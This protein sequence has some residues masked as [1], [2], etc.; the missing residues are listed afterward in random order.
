MITRYFVDHVTALI[1]I[2]ALMFEKCKMCEPL[3]VKPSKYGVI[4]SCNGTFDFV[5]T[6]IGEAF[7]LSTCRKAFRASN[8]LFCRDF[9]VRPLF[10]GDIIFERVGQHVSTR[11][12]ILRHCST[13]HYA[14]PSMARRIR[15]VF[16]LIVLRRE[17]KTL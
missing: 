8:L 10:S 12:I 2:V 11:D 7:N 17:K 1:C 9:L 15:E 5:S 13:T 14:V 3:H 6:R 16:T 4:S